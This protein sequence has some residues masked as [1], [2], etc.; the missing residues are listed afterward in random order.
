MKQA[1]VFDWMKQIQS[2]QAGDITLDE[3][4]AAVQAIQDQP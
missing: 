2:V 4:L 1:V 3:A